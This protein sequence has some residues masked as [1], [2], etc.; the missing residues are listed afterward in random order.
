MV[1][2]PSLDIVYKMSLPAC[3]VDTPSLDIVCKIPCLY[4]WYTYSRYC[5]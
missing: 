2:T 1:D 3:M 4:G 5:V